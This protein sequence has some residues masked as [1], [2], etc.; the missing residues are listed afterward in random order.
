[1]ARGG[2]RKGI[3][4][5]P[6]VIFKNVFDLYNFSIISN[7]FGSDYV[8]GPGR[9]PVFPHMARR[10]KKL[11]TP[12]SNSPKVF[13]VEEKGSDAKGSEVKP[14]GD[15]LLTVLLPVK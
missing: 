14:V 15:L 6:S 9:T 10:I 2:F 7:L 8:S 5:L 1:M 4:I 3:C 13:F 11:P 12:G